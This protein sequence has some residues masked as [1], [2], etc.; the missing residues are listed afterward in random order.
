M[1]IILY[2]FFDKTVGTI[3]ERD[4][5]TKINDMIVTVTD[6]IG[7]PLSGVG[8]ATY[9]WNDAYNDWIIINSEFNGDTLNFLTEELLISNGEVQLTNVPLDNKIWGITIIEN[10]LIL[11]DLRLSDLSIN[12]A[13]ISLLDEYNG[14]NIRFT[15]AFGSIGAQM[16][17]YMEYKIDNLMNGVPAS[18]NTVEKLVNGYNLLNFNTG[19]ISDFEA[20]L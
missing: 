2:K 5:L 8:T 15:Y 3:A 10:D 6:A 16:E 1:A 19:T 20:S 13:T 11:K 7:D 18:Y 14:K 9:R 12:G 4:S 17:A